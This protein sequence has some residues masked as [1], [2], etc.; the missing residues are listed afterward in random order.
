MTVGRHQAPRGQG[1]LV[2]TLVLFIERAIDLLRH[3]AAGH[4]R[5]ARRPGAAAPPPGAQ[6]GAWFRSAT[7]P[8]GHRELPAR[9]AR[10][11]LPRDRAAD[12]YA[13]AVGLGALTCACIEQL[14][15]ARQIRGGHDGLIHSLIDSAVGPHMTKNPPGTS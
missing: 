11:R 12:L 1:D 10:S 9:L 4:C 7:G 15:G 3:G 2:A 13:M 8:A 14:A 6:P 5:V